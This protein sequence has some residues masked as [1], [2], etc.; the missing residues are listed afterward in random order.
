MQKV[1]IGTTGISVTELCHG[2]LILG[3]LQADLS[4]EEGAHILGAQ[5]NVWTEYMPT[6]QQV[7]Y[8]AFP[9]ASAL[10]EVVWSSPDTRDF[11]DFM[12][13]LKVFMKRL[14]KLNVNFRDPFKEENQQ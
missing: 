5:G 1:N 6:F 12:K 14:R 8:M 13:R 3:N 9:R 7:E 10:A 4:P 2:T 11:Q